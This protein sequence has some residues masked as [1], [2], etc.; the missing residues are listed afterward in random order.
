MPDFVGNVV[1][2]LNNVRMWILAIVP[3]AGGM[4]IA[5]HALQKKLA[6]GD[7]GEMA[8]RDRKIKDVLKST[9]I[10]FIGLGIVMAIAA[11][12]GGGTQNF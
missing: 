1:N 3:T 4:M 11:A 6:D 12:F 8:E 9:A 10:A 5:W 2:L 7:A